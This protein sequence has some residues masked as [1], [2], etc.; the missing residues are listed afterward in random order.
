MMRPMQSPRQTPLGLLIGLCGLGALSLGAPLALGDEVLLKNGATFQGKILSDDPSRIVLRTTAG[1]KLTL[2]RSQIAKVTRKATSE[3]AEL[4]Y[5]GRRALKKGERDSAIQFFKEAAAS[6]DESAVRAA[7]EE[8]RRLERGDEV[9]EASTGRRIP[10]ENGKDPFD[11][12]E[13]EAIL[14]ELEAAAK[15]GDDGARQRWVSRLYQRAR[16]HEGAKRYLEAAVDYQRA[17]DH[18][19]GLF[20]KD[21]TRP[22][23]EAA[24]VNRLRVA[25]DA[26]RRRNGRLALAAAGPV[27]ESKLTP[28]SLLASAAYFQGRGLELAN[29]RGE[30]IKAYATTFGEVVPSRKDVE[31]Y[32]ELARLTTVGIKVGP[33]S[34]GVGRE[35]HRVETRHFS[36]LHQLEK[37]DPE[38]GLRFEKWREAAYTRLQL[39]NLPPKD[40]IQVFLYRDREAYQKSEGA[41]SWS[42][43]HATR[44][45]AAHDEDEVLRVIY[46]FPSQN[47]ASTARHEIAHILTWDSLGEKA[48]LPLWAVEGAA[49]YAEPDNVRM[50]RRRRAGQWRKGLDPTRTALARMLFPVT[51][52][53]EDVGRFYV[54]SGVN[55]A[56]IA[57][58][59]GVAKAFKVA[60]GINTQGPQKALRAAGLDL[61]AFE[62][63]V[64]KA[65][66]GALPQAPAKKKSP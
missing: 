1:A 11:P 57:D 31:T 38:L 32:R 16:L 59:I 66:G 12:P 62:A 41:R 22:W 24:A 44:L 43:G 28:R 64:E 34:P 26:V 29:R 58:R 61:R 45:Q 25:R 42:A 40:R 60:L 63:D 10:F 51:K 13:P 4:F 56:V 19:K 46:F 5:A 23:F 18:A 55:F 36:I 2:P 65:I 7:K 52:T 8:L 9:P 53:N 6:D 54:Q 39:K 35:W 48:E 27:V 30:A 3:G 37:R 20:G 49:I 50:W 21:F 33:G 14:R 17:S 47:D 15:Q